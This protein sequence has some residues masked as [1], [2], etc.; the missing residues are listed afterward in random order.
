MRIIRPILV[1]DSNFLSSTVEEDD[2]PLWAI[3]TA[4]LLGDEVLL[5]HVVYKAAS[6]NTGKDPRL[7]ENRTIWPIKGV[8][9]RWRMFDMTRGV[10][11]QTVDADEIVVTVRMTQLYSAVAL[12]GLEAKTAKIEIIDGS[13]GVVYENQLMTISNTGVNTFFDWFYGYS[14]RN[15]STQI[16]DFNVPYCPGATLRATISRP[17]GVAKIGKLVYG[18][19]RDLG[20]TSFGTELRFLDF[21]RRDRDDFGNLVFVERRKISER[22]FQV[23][24]D[25]AKITS[26]EAT[27]KGLDSTPTVFVGSANHEATI[28]FGLPVDFGASYTYKKTNYSLKV[29]EF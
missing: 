29:Q 4:Y 11:I 18:R 1:G 21:S 7:P 28:I 14:Q 12:F 8:S 13:N 6:D 27:I 15:R 16:V 17:G 19:A 3:G 10:E 2:A 5:D 20:C 22:T 24:V 26:V 25:S 23:K 9:N